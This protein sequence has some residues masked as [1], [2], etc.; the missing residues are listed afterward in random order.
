MQDRG[1]SPPP[2]AL[3]L[4]VMGSGGRGESFLFPDQD[5]GIIIADYPDDAHDRIDGSRVRPPSF[6]ETSCRTRRCARPAR[7]RRRNP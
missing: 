6:S 1:R 4:I 3:S 5:N 2:V 7:N